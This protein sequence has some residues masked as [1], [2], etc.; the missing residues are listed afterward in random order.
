MES[1][2]SVG[3]LKEKTTTLVAWGRMIFAL[4]L[5]WIVTPTLSRLVLH[6]PILCNERIEDWAV[7]LTGMLFGIVLLA[8]IVFSAERYAASNDGERTR[9]AAN[10]F[11]DFADSKYFRQYYRYLYCS[12]LF[13]V[14]VLVVTYFKLRAIIASH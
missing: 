11:T 2:E 12:S 9:N 1:D 4:I 5:P 6:C 3:P 14:V 7:H 8:T 10:A 13:C